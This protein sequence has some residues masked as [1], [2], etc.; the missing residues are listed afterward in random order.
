METMS[1]EVH[2]MKRRRAAESPTD[3]GEQVSQINNTPSHSA[4]RLVKRRCAYDSELNTSFTDPNTE[5]FSGGN[6]DLRSELD[7]VHLMYNTKVEQIELVQRNLQRACEEQAEEL[8]RVNQE[9]KLLKRSLI[10][11][12]GK[13]AEAEKEVSDS[14]S[15]IESLRQ[16][17]RELE[18][19][20]MALC[21]HGQNSINSFCRL[22]ERGDRGSGNGGPVC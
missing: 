16:R 6:A 1:P 8:R 15:C 10:T 21:L 19:A 11:L 17:C 22:D 3:F 4:T 9:N 7:K 2:V 5:I 20:N 13:R 14:R 12:N 18:Q